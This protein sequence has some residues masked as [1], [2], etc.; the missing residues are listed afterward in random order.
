M[1]PH[2]E[3]HSALEAKLKNKYSLKA[4]MN[5]NHQFGQM[6][7]NNNNNGNGMASISKLESIQ[8]RIRSVLK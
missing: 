1:K 6:T 7:E 4:E 8:Q 2:A 5:T 3:V